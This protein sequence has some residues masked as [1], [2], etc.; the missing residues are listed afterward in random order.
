MNTKE[1]QQARRLTIYKHLAR[2]VGYASQSIVNDP[3]N[4]L[5][6]Q[7]ARFCHRPDEGATP[8]DGYLVWCEIN[9]IRAKSVSLG[10]HFRL[11]DPSPD[12]KLR[13]LYMDVELEEHRR[14]TQ[15]EQSV[16]KE[17]QNKLREYLAT[18]SD[19]GDE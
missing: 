1:R 4:E 16:H 7:I 9:D 19:E 11:D 3:V 15:R 14:R 6:Y 8:L 12:E 2:R 18:R 13:E 10:S 17:E 5:A